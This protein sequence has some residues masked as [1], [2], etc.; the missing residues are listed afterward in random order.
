MSYTPVV[1]IKTSIDKIL[2]LSNAMQNLTIQIMI[3]HTESYFPFRDITWPI[4]I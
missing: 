1:I 2:I 3:A 4:S